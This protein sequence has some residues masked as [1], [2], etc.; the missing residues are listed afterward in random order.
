ME[1]LAS[2]LSVLIK[3]TAVNGTDGVLN[4]TTELWN[5]MASV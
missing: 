4:E 1:Y 3:I 5:T 2:V